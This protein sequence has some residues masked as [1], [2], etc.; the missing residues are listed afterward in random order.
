MPFHNGL[1]T[2]AATH[3]YLHGEKV[4][5]GLL[6]QLVLEGKPRSVLD[7]VLGFAT[8]VGLPITLD[9][10][11][12]TD[13]SPDVLEAIAVRA[14]APDDT[15]HNEPFEVKPDMVADALLAA[16]EMGRAWKKVYPATTRDP[17]PTNGRSL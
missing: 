11:G 9:D 17:D 2:A 8:D 10:I 3:G 5:F 13:V 4:A 15:I 16:D 14:S 12:L 7:P 6:T 1:T